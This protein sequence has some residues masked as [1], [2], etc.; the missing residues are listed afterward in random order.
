MIEWDGNWWSQGLWLESS[1]ILKRTWIEL[2]IWRVVCAVFPAPLP[3]VD[4]LTFLTWESNC[5]FWLYFYTAVVFLTGMS[6]V[7]SFTFT[8][9]LFF[10]EKFTFPLKRN[11]LAPY[12]TFYI[13]KIFSRGKLLFLKS[14]LFKLSKSLQVL[15][16]RH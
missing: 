10:L 16:I 2:G 3:L 9:P 8:F 5:C 1:M 7:I 4:S 13:F 12:F 14:P 15:V 11:H 6:I